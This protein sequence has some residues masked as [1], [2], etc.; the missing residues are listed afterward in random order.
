[1]SDKMLSLKRELT[2]TAERL[3]MSALVDD[4]CLRLLHGVV[5]SLTMDVAADESALITDTLFSTYF[6]QSA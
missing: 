3:T 1:M 2:A 5:L 6:S 4:K